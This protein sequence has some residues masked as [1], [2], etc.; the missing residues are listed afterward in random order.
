MD[1][2]ENKKIAEDRDEL[3]K[4]LE[5]E[6]K[7]NK[8]REINYYKEFPIVG[9]TEK[10]SG[11]KEKDIFIVENEK[12]V[13]GITIKTF[14]IYNKDK[15]KIAE[16]DI[17][18]LLKYDP[19]YKEQL[20]DK[21]K[22]YYDQ[23]GLDDEQRKN[24]LHERDFI[25]EKEE[26][27]FISKEKGQ[28]V[29]EKKEDEMTKEEKD[30]EIEKL[31]EN[32]E[33]KADILEQKL[34]EEDLELDTK[35]L[36]SITKI[37]DKRFYDKV[38]E[39]RHYDG[40]AMLV[41]NKKLNQFMVIGMQ[42]GKYVECDSIEPSYATMKTSIDLDRTGKKVERQ[43]IG[44]IM[45]LKGNNDYDFAVNIESFGEIE[46]QELR[47]DENGKYMS[48]DLQVQGKY[49]TSY[50]VEKMM[51]KGRNKHISDEREEF[52]K[53]QKHGHT[54]SVQSL[55]DKDCIREENA[56]GEISDEDEME[57]LDD[58]DKARIRQEDEIEEKEEWERGRR[59]DPRWY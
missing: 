51:D 47:K 49:Q 44:G 3:R 26:D 55:R 19:E 32:R 35:D 29:G 21:L 1:I 31:R 25:V 22:D 33:N 28:I 43:E 57:M 16:T 34:V 14:E 53:E 5:Q 36:G 9:E 52:Q 39:A 30:E 24:Y 2:D 15:Q 58:T 46:F 23:L 7:D 48:A 37:K 6:N 13:D 27:N 20:K 11:F 41:Y 56:N 12:Q 8:I 50:E 18:G 4:K 17:D 10:Y 40:D 42:D 38:P 59:P 45:K 54:S